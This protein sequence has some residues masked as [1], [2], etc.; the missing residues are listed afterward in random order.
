[1]WD[2]PKECGLQPSRVQFV[3]TLGMESIT[4]VSWWNRNQLRKF[5]LIF[6]EVF[7]V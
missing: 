4:P 3:L 6:D 2:L 5:L 1:M 7:Y